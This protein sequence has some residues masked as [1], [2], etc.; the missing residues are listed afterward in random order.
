MIAQL[1]PFI[2]PMSKEIA[3]S[4]NDFLRIGKLLEA[5]ALCHTC[6]AL[7]DM[8]CRFLKTPSRLGTGQLRSQST[9]DQHAS[10]EHWCL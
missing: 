9:Y 4:F 3:G 6:V 1:A 8:V 5:G 7:R 10:R 2:R